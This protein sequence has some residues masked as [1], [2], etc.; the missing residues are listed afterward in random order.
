MIGVQGALH[1]SFIPSIAHEN[2]IPGN[3]GGSIK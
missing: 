1:V 3:F 2:M